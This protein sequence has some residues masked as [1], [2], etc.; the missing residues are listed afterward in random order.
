MFQSESGKR[1]A[2]IAA[3]RMILGLVLKYRNGMLFVFRRGYAS[4]L[5][6]SNWFS[7][8]RPVGAKKCPQAQCGFCTRWSPATFGCSP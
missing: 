1:T 7:L 5:S 8:T 2:S 4:A 6:V 3:R